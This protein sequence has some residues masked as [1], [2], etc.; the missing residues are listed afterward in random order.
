MLSLGRLAFI[1]AHRSA[2]NEK[3][4]ADIR[5]WQD[6][7]GVSPFWTGLSSRFINVPFGEAEFLLSRDQDFLPNAIPSDP[8]YL[9]LLDRQA[10]A[11]IGKANDN[12]MGAIKLLRS[13]GFSMTKFCNV[14]DGGPALE[15]AALET[16]VA[17]TQT[18]VRGFSST[19]PAERTLQ[20]SGTCLL[21]TSP[22][23]R[24][25]R[26]SRMPSSA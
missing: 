8:I 5:G 26:Q 25:K 20:Y 9:Q 7:Q 24:D 4:M 17:K 21:Y 16:V 2:F 14:L 6:E 18:A 12:S 13:A 1:N 15:C 10:R 3:L 22:S 19:V 11:C 23:P